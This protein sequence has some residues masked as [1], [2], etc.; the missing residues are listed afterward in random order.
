MYG[1]KYDQYPEMAKA[2]PDMSGLDTLFA[3]V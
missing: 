3:D 2:C 1:I